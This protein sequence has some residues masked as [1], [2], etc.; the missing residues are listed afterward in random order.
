MKKIDLKFD[1]KRFTVVII[2]CVAIILI[3]L[4]A[5]QNIDAKEILE[6]NRDLQNYNAKLQILD[7]K[8]HQ[9]AEFSIALADTEEKKMYGLMNLDQLPEDCGMLFPFEKS[10]VIAMWMRNTRIPLDMIFI[11]EDDK[12]VNIAANTTPYSLDIISSEKES[13]KVLEVN[14]GL[15]KKLK[16]KVGNKVRVL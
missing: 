5:A 16:I 7:S 8:Q 12:I 11:G 10:Q 2:S 14:G 9:I 1:L 15:A 4:R 13:K 3:I 6:F